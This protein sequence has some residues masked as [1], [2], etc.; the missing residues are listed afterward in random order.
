[1]VIYTAYGNKEELPL[2]YLRTRG[3]DAEYKSSSSAS[4][5]S[6]DV[7]T[8][9]EK[10]RILDTDSEAQRQLKLKKTKFLRQQN[11]VVQREKESTVVQQNWQK[12][13]A[14]GARKNLAGMSGITGKGSHDSISTGAAPKAANTANRK[15]QRFH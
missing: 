10:Y 3:T 6:G 1:M 14:K 12:F 4:T 9:P 11:R 2:A 5:L 15:R 7:K 13:V 8:I